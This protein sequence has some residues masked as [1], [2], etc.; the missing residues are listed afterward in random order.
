MGHRQDEPVEAIPALA[1]LHRPVEGGNGI[2]PFARAEVGKAERIPETPDLRSVPDHFAAKLQRLLGVAEL[3]V[4]ASEQE[5]GEIVA[6][7]DAA[8]DVLDLFGCRIA[9]EALLDQTTRRSQLIR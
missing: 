8:A 7:D 9:T 1:K 4:R 3:L 6:R 5:P 2:L